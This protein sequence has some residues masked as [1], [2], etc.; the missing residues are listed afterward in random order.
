MKIK[1][2]LIIG[3]IILI[4]LILITGLSFIFLKKD[5]KYGSSIHGS[6]YEDV[7]GMKELGLD[8]V[9]DDLVWSNVEKT[10]GVYDFSWA[11]ERMDKLDAK[12][13]EMNWLLLYSNNLYNNCPSGER[14]SVYV[15]TE[16]DK[17]EIFKEAYGDYCYE[18][19]KHYK[20]RVKYFEIWNEPY[21]F[22][23]PINVPESYE[24]QAKQ[25]TELAKE[26]YTRGKE[27]NK[28]AVFLAGGLG[29][30]N[31]LMTKYIKVMFENGFAD[32]YDIFGIHPYCGY[33]ES[34]PLENQGLTCE[35]VENIRNLKSLMNKYGGK[36]EMWITEFGYPTAGC[37]IDRITNKL[38]GCAR[39]LTEEYQ[40]IRMK[41][42]FKTIKKIPEVTAFFW[43]DYRSDCE[44]RGYRNIQGC[45]ATEISEKCP[46]YSE[47]NFGLTRYDLSR[48]PAWFSYQEIIG[49]N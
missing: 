28:D 39:N 17:F 42:I 49:K 35:P 31:T 10:K 20:G 23:S 27:A 44:I 21:I 48:K 14:C 26:C 9:R 18:S 1:D 8:I 40:D 36:T 13:I 34:F 7:D 5:F 45:S 2:I 47:C 25:Y 16:P 46:L 24:F 6:H 41:N 33:D 19:V 4:M 32:Y 30:T 12:G 3:G 29:L 43:Y 22:W 38:R 11:D 37:S 15:P